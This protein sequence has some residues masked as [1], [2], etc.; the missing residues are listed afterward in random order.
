MRRT[1]RALAL[2][3][4]LLAVAPFAAAQQSAAP[5]NGNPLA[6][7]NGSSSFYFGKPGSSPLNTSSGIGRPE[8]RYAAVTPVP[9]PSQWLMMLAGLGIV[10][11]IVRRSSHR[12]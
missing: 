6:R 8:N 10:G 9:E 3:I 2:A 11:F 12:S 5:A 7:S 1:Y 4:S